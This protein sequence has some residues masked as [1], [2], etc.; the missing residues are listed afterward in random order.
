M[1]WPS[2]ARRHNI[3][4]PR[5]QDALWASRK[6]GAPE[7]TCHDVRNDP[8]HYDNR[9]EDCFENT[10][11][12]AHEQRQQQ[13][14][15]SLTDQGRKDQVGEQNLKGIEKLAVPEDLLK[16]LQANPFDIPRSYS[17]KQHIREGNIDR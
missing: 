9:A 3:Q 13:P 10:V 16:I 7:E 8:G 5:I 4:Q 2:E 15:S 11:A 17:G 14:K 6:K 12:F 1:L